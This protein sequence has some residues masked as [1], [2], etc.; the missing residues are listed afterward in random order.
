[1]VGWIR[2][3]SRVSGAY[4][5]S[6]L[7]SFGLVLVQ[8]PGQGIV[9]TIVVI[10]FIDLTVSWFLGTCGNDSI[11]FTCHDDRIYGNR[12]C[13]LGPLSTKDCERVNGIGFSKLLE[14]SS[15]DSARSVLAMERSLEMDWMGLAPLDVCFPYP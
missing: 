10:E 4:S 7:V 6:V 13:I 1:M 15:F 11:G 3:L 9:W 8:N 12:Q 14:G 2:R 5:A